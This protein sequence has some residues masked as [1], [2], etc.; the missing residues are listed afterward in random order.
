MAKTE[1]KKNSVFTAL[2]AFAAAVILLVS[3]FTMGAA[4]LFFGDNFYASIKISEIL[5]NGILNTICS[6]IAP[7]SFI[8]GLIVF[9]LTSLLF[10]GILKLTEKSEKL[11]KTGIIWTLT[12]FTLRAFALIFWNLPQ[13]SDFKLNYEVS[14]LISTIPI[15]Y[16]GKFVHEMNIQYTGVWSAHMPFIIYQSFALKFGA[17]LGLLNAFYGTASCVF[18]AL[19]AKEIF[20][21]KAFT[22][23][24]II[25]ALNPLEILFT[26]VL[27]N[28]HISSVFFTAAIWFLSRS[29]GTGITD[30]IICAL[31]IGLSQI[32]RPEMYVAVIGIILFYIILNISDGDKK[33]PIKAILFIGVFA[34]VILVFD[35]I[36]RLSGLISGH[37]FS[38]NMGYKL[39][40]GLNTES[41]GGWS[42]ADVALIGNSEL[43]AQTLKER[44]SGGGIIPLMIQ[45]VIYQFGS[46]VYPWILDMENNPEFSNI[47]CRRA[48]SAYMII[49]T[50]LASANLFGDRHSR[51]KM[52]PLFIIIL[53]Y[54]AAYSLIEVQAR[55]NYVIIPLLTILG[56]DIGNGD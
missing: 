4:N 13:V 3:A 23:A 47:I 46:Y 34:A 10:Y 25:M 24:I 53:G 37:I 6:Y 16:W 36:F 33:A 40:L 20:G 32:F 45:K 49:V 31:L 52:F 5:D 39:C 27:T 1:H 17:N 9:L 15:G 51:I 2:T 21:K 26:P 44:L 11:I 48:V 43:I 28:Q 8:T 50:V 54:M 30:S 55:Y 14:E 29:R 7:S 19:A 56:A 35:C 22:A 18:T 38:G 42:E 41:G 12:A